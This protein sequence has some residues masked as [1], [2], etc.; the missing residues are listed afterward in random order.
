MEALATIL[1]APVRFC[2]WLIT[3]PKAFIGLAFLFVALLML[4]NCATG[5]QS[6]SVETPEYQTIAPTIKEAPYI[7]QTSSR[8]YYVVEYENTGGGL[9]L[10]EYFTYDKKE[11][12][13]QTFPLTLSEQYY[14]KVVLNERKE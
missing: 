10:L 5:P 2:R 1:A 8:V 4:R 14:G 11:W 12:Q 13:K 7:V 6:A 9:T 3:H